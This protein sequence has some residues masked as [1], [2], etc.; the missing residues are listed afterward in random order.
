MHSLMQLSNILVL[1]IL[2]QDGQLAMSI[3][4][5]AEIA[6]TLRHYS[7]LPVSFSEIH[8][9]CIEVTSIL[10]KSTQSGVLEVELIQSLK[11]TG[12]LLWDHLFTKAVK[13][14]LK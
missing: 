13:E 12:Q 4:E 10:N 9:L 1:E 7:Q 3:F 14:N 8:K 6:S 5:Q 11:K 2:R